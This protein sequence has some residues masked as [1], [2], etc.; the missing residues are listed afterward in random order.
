MEQ[1]IDLVEYKKPR[2][3]FSPNTQELS[4]IQ[5]HSLDENIKKL[6]NEKIYLKL[7]MKFN[8]KV[9]DKKRLYTMSI[10]AMKHRNAKILKIDDIYFASKFMKI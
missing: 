10:E 7:C 9:Y 5:Q 6:Q 4:N 8:I 3:I 1:I 2:S